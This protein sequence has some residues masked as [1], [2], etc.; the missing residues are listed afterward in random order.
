MN[1]K[2]INGLLR[3]TTA[4]VIALLLAGCATPTPGPEPTC[5]GPCGAIAYSERVRTW[6]FS[7]NAPNDAIARQNAVERC[8]SGDCAI[9]VEFG[10][11][12]CAA[13]AVSASG[14]GVGSGD[15]ALVAEQQAKTACKQAD[16]LLQPAECNTEIVEDAPPPPPLV[17]EPPEM[18]LAH[19]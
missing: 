13:L 11:R 1:T 18:S 3:M 9:V 10:P 15:N 4:T 2:T 19:F 8:R 6:G 12:Q 7:W 17:D 14:Y 5:T 16:C